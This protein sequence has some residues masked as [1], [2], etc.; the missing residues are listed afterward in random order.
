MTSRRTELLKKSITDNLYDTE[1]RFN[2]MFA[3]G[4]PILS[5]YD[6]HVLAMTR[7]NL[8]SK[9][10]IALELGWRDWQIEQLNERIKEIEQIQ[11]KNE[12]K[13]Y[14][15]YYDNN[16]IIEQN[17]LIVIVRGENAEEVL[18]HLLEKFRFTFKRY[19]RIKEIVKNETDTIDF[20]AWSK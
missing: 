11:E 10:D 12:T 15:C 17:T 20:F 9:S 6:R 7:E 19:W 2:E 14:F 5:H 18:S 3:L 13:Q 8:D 1:N 4:H 16:E